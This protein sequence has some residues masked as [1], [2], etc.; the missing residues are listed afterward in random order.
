MG[1]SN[2]MAHGSDPKKYAEVGQNLLNIGH[3]MEAEAI[4]AVTGT[5]KK[6]EKIDAEEE[7]N[8]KRKQSRIEAAEED[9]L[10]E[11][12]LLRLIHMAEKMGDVDVFKSLKQRLFGE[13]APTLVN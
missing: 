5:T 1:V 2:Y 7:Q 13:S 9:E 8:R 11:R 3:M 4:N 10:C 6:R 12:K